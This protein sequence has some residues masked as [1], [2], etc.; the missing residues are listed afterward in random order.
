[1]TACPHG[2]FPFNTVW[3]LLQALVEGEELKEVGAQLRQKYEV[4][5]EAIKA[6]T[7]HAVLCAN[8]STLRSLVDMRRVYTDPVNMV[9]IMT[10]RRVREQPD[11]RSLRV[12]VRLCLI[13]WGLGGQDIDAL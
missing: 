11:D 12:R 3:V 13:I 6:I 2:T 4:S 9:Q 1:M 5:T 7:E 8:N 10:L